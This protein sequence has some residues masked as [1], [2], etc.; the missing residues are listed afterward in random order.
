M[1]K[2]LRKKSPSSLNLNIMN[3]SSL[4]VVLYTHCMTL[5]THWARSPAA[6]LSLARIVIW[7]GVKLGLFTRGSTISTVAFFI[8]S[9]SNRSSSSLNRSKLAICRLAPFAHVESEFGAFTEI[10]QKYEINTLQ[11]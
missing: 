10:T 6:L 7:S 2:F 1:N 3:F 11:I 8:G 5:R 4:N 9:C